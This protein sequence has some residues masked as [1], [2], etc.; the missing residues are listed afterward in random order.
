VG[1]FA[2]RHQATPEEIAD[3]VLFAA[4]D[5]ACFA[6]GSDL[7]ADSGFMLGPIA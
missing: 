4:S 5:Q 7:L 3:F 1:G 6:I 2:I